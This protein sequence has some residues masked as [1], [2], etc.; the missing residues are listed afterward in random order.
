MCGVTQ[1]FSLCVCCQCRCGRLGGPIFTLHRRLFDR[2]AC[3]M[4]VPRQTRQIHHTS[5]RVVV[6]SPV[7]ILPPPVPSCPPPPDLPAESGPSLR[8]GADSRCGRPAH[9]ERGGT[10]RASRC[11]PPPPQLK[12]G[13]TIGGPPPADATRHWPRVCGR[14]G[15]RITIRKATI[16]EFRDGLCWS[17][18]PGRSDKWPPL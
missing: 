14:A 17:S 5:G 13:P 18:R 11:R 6:F 9:L 2:F 12:S 1:C 7:D 4:C 3:F 10:R 8:R 16:Y 15:Q